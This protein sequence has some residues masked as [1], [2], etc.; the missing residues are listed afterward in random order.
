M[1]LREDER[2]SERISNVELRRE[3]HELWKK[4]FEACMNLSVS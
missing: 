2:E 1:N 3:K 4:L